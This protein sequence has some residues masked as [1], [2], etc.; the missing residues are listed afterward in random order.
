VIYV[1][2]GELEPWIEREKRVLGPGDAAF[3][4]ADTVHALFN[5]GRETSSCS[6]SSVPP[7]EARVWR[8]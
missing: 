2:A 5:I 3:I 6:R 8:R 4:P 7:W 1:L